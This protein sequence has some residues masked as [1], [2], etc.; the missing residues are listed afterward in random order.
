MKG[1][2][3]AEKYYNAHGAPM[4]LK[5]FSRYQE[6]IAV[7]FVGP[8]SECFGFDDELSRDH[9]WGPGFCLWL[10]AEDYAQF[11]TALQVE[12]AKLPQTFM[13][14]GPRVVSPG[15]EARTGVAEII[16]FYK[17]YTG[18]D[19]IP[20]SIR[21]WMFIPEQA[22]ATCTNGRV[23]SDPLGEFTRWRAK[24]LDFYPEDI[25]LKKIASR[26]MTIAQAGQYNYDRS[27]KRR[28]SFSALY[29]ETQF[30][31]DV[32]SLVFLMNR[33]YTPFYKWMHRA[34][35]E[36]PILGKSI[37]SIIANLIDTSDKVEKRD[38]I[39]NIS[40]LI[41]EELRRMGLS[42]S[43]SDFLLDHARNIHNKI[44][45][46]VLRGSFSLMQ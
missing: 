46:E 7:G 44:Q 37:Q 6:R 13:G 42:N 24:L 32:I 23:F 4:L 1:L 38:I 25:R 14:F 12:Y 9:D 40:A 15:E 21:D 28:E 36:L 26:C 27:I 45:D 34:V 31:T 2:R 30:C 20:Q 8:G 39:E 19:R 43:S 5:K 16:A 35:G 10:T 18:L 41:I 17:R 29:A 3:L 22:L 33:K 11:G